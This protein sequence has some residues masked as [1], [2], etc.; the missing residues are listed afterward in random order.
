MHLH[1]YG[2]LGVGVCG[3]HAYGPHA[4]LGGLAELELQGH[5]PVAALGE[6]GAVGGCSSL[7][8]AGTGEN[9]S[10][11]YRSLNQLKC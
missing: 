1:A 8:D 3:L 2:L 9:Y 6:R 4:L 10:E 11:R 5:G 7:C